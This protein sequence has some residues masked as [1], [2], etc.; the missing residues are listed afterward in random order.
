MHKLRELKRRLRPSSDKVTSIIT[1][2]IDAMDV[3]GKVVPAEFG[4]GV[5]SAMSTILTAIRVNIIKRP[6]IPLSRSDYALFV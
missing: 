5:L 2:L 1:P 4:G 6:R 3:A